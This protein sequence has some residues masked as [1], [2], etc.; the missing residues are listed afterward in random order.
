[1]N[2]KKQGLKWN[3][4]S[5]VLEYV[6]YLKKRGYSYRKLGVLCNVHNSTVRKHLLKYRERKYFW[7]RILRFFK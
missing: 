5:K 1:M 3:P 2:I 7:S 4:S 6:D